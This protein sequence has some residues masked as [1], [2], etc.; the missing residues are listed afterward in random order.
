MSPEQAEMN[1]LDVDSRSDVYSLGVLLYELLT[2]TTPFERTQLK[3]VGLDEM[4]RIIQEEEPPRP[5]HRI[6]TL[7]AEASTT[8]CERRGVDVRRL[9]QFL[10]GELDW[11]VMKALEKDRNRRYESASALAA[12]VQCYLKDEPVAACPPAAGYRLRKFARVPLLEQ[13]LEKQ[14]TICGP[15]HLST[16]ETMHLLATNYGDVDRL[17]ESLALYEQVFGLVKSTKAPEPDWLGWRILGYVQVRQRAGKLDQADQLLRQQLE[18][19]RK[20]AD[21]LGR[22][23]N[24]ANTLGWQALNLLLRQ[25]YAEAEPL[26]REAVTSFE[27]HRFNDANA[28]RRFYW[29][30]LLGAV[31][32]GQERYAEAE[33]LLLEGYEGMKQRE[34][35]MHAS[36]RRRLAEA[37]ERIVRFY[38]T[39]GQ[40]EQAS[41]WREKLDAAP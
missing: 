14:R 25:Q 23:P 35:I 7:R 10:Q 15:T 4:R 34:A 16:L 30:S 19:A 33:P 36:E 31:L 22:R 20:R 5:S 2:G 1:G 9:R 40:P 32:S 18:Y 6:S 24:I 27:Q 17:A 39:T 13:V 29:V 12:D 37:G 11:I 38:E 21:S 28:A 41:A 3:Q 8:A 26:V